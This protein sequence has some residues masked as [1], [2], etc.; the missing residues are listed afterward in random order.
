MEHSSSEGFNTVC[1]LEAFSLQG[2]T[3]K[4]V[5][6][7]DLDE[8]VDASSLARIG[9]YSTDC[10]ILMMPTAQTSL[11]INHQYITFISHMLTYGKWQLYLHSTQ[12]EGK[13]KITWNKTSSNMSTRIN[14]KTICA[15]I[16]VRTM[17]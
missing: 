8:V 6:I 1:Y 15:R 2:T 4:I 16:L 10:A 12:N 7:R 9:Q 5:N 17:Y 11:C 13:I 3:W 14:T